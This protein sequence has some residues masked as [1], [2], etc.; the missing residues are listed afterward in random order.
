MVKDI[1]NNSYVSVVVNGNKLTTDKRCKHG[2]NTIHMRHVDSN[3]RPLSKFFKD[4]NALLTYIN[5]LL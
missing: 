5:K 3:V 1:I 4:D 2:L